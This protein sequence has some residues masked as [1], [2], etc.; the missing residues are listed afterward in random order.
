[1]GRPTKVTGAIPAVRGRLREGTERNG[2]SINNSLSSVEIPV[3][4]CDVSSPS[5]VSQSNL[6][7]SGRPSV[8]GPVQK[9]FGRSLISVGC[10]RQHEY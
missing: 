10:T 1:M 2:L 4:A 8:H 5:F 3:D 9:M 6:A 7:V